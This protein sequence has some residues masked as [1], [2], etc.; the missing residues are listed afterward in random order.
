MPRVQFRSSE[1]ESVLLKRIGT[2]FNLVD[3]FVSKLA[4]ICKL[5]QVGGSPIITFPHLKVETF[6]EV[7]IAHAPGG[8]RSELWEKPFLKK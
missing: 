2:R 6:F 8:R 4:T 3:K 1:Q 5:L 7:A